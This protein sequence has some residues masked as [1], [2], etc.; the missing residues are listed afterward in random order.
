MTFGLLLGLIF[1]SFFVNLF[2]WRRFF[3]AKY[4]YEEHDPLF[5][6]YC[7]RNPAT[8]NILI[9]LSY[10]LSFQAIRLTYS[11]FLGKKRFMAKFTKRLRYFRLIGRLTVF[12]TLFLY[13]PAVIINSWSLTY[14][15]DRKTTQ[16]WL[17]VDGLA[18]VCYSVILISVVL[19]QREKLMNEKSYFNFGELFKFGD[20]TDA[21]PT[22]ETY[23]NTH[24]TFP[25]KGS[26]RGENASVASIQDHTFKQQEER[27]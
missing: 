13:L 8:S 17:N 4:K 2:L 26:V 25:S 27:K 20:D 10:L 6:E 24:Q 22:T 15:T 11:R 5:S 14:I 21:I 9:F 16:F 7:R 19:T 23:G 12:E 1:I 3:Y 18:L